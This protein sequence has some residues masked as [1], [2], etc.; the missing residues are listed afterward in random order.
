MLKSQQSC[1][2]VVQSRPRLVWDEPLLQFSLCLLLPDGFWVFLGSGS[3]C[4]V[5]GATDNSS[6][7]GLCCTHQTRRTSPRRVKRWRWPLLEM[8]DHHFR[9]DAV[10]LFHHPK[11][12]S[13]MRREPCT[14][15]TV[16]R[17]PM[18]REP[19][20]QRIPRIRR[21]HAPTWASRRHAKASV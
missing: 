1:L 19:V 10:A 3:S 5:G 8:A 2:W 21:K 20:M 6:T 7:E 13:P 14:V 17:V 18:L 4:S 16:M 11:T 15:C 12:I 9:V